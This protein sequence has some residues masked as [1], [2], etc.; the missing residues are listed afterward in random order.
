MPDMDVILA[1]IGNIQRY[2]RRIKE[3]TGLDPERSRYN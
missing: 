2:L 1:K 3:T